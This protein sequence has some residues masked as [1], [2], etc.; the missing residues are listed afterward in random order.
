MGVGWTLRGVNVSNSRMGQR[1]AELSS[2]HQLIFPIDTVAVRPR[3]EEGPAA[4][5]SLMRTGM[6]CAKLTIRKRSY[7]LAMGLGRDKTQQRSIAVE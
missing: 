7:L 4:L 6:R 3:R 2:H 1:N 5:S